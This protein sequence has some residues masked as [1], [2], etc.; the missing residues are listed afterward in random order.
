M[1]AHSPVPWW[2]TD[3]FFSPKGGV[4][5]YLTENTQ[6]A[7][8]FWDQVRSWHKNRPIPEGSYVDRYMKEIGFTR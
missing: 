8:L 6:V 7:H 3:I 2:L 5:P 1:E 4:E